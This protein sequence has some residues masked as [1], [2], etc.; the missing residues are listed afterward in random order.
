MFFVRCCI[1]VCFVVVLVA[2]ASCALEDRVT[3][4]ESDVTKARLVPSDWRK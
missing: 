3:V 1:V 2:M 4:V